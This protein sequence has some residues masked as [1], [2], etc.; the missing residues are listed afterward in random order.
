MNR[1]RKGLIIAASLCGAAVGLTVAISASVVGG[2][3][4]LVRDHNLVI[5]NEKETQLI[6]GVTETKVTTRDE[7]GNNQLVSY[8]TE[9][10]TSENSNI[11]V[12]AGYTDMNFGRVGLSTVRQQASIAQGLF[13]SNNENKTIIS[14]INA[15]PFNMSTG[16]NVGP[17][18]HDGVI[19][20]QHHGDPAQLGNA[21]FSVL[22]DG[23]FQT[24]RS[25]EEF[26]PQRETIAECVSGM[27]WL[28]HDGVTLDVDSNMAPDE[29]SWYGERAPRTAIGY[30]AA[31][32]LM[33]IV[34][35][36]RN[37]PIS[38]GA[39]YHEVAQMFLQRG[40][41]YAIALDG[42]GSATLLSKEEGDSQL[43]L[44]NVPSDGAE[45]RVGSSLLFYVENT[46]ESSGFQHA[47]I[48]PKNDYYTPT[49]TITFS[50]KGVDG[51]G[52]SADIPSGSSWA[53]ENP[54]LGTI[55]TI[56]ET[57]ARFTPNADTRGAVKVYLRDS[58][59]RNIGNTTI[60]I[61]LPDQLIFTNNEKS[62]GFD[63]DTDLGLQA[64]YQNVQVNYNAEDIDFVIK[65][66]SVS[67]NPSDLGY[68]NGTLFHSH[69]SNSI[70][71]TII[72]GLKANPSI[73]SSIKIIVGANPTVIDDFESYSTFEDLNQRWY[74]YNAEGLEEGDGYGRG[75]K[76]SINLARYDEGKP[77]RFG[78][79]SLE[80][81]WDFTAT[82]GGTSGSSAGF[83]DDNLEV[84]GAP[85]AYGAWI[86]ATPEAQG[87][88]LRARIVDGSGA[89]QQL[90]LTCQPSTCPPGVSHGINWIGWKYVE[91]P[92]NP[93]WPLPMY[94]AKGESLRFM[95]V[96]GTKPPM[97]QKNSG[98]FYVDNIQFVYG[99]NTD[100]VDSPII[101]SIQLNG[102]DFTEDGITV[103]TNS[104][105]YI[106]SFHDQEGTYAT[107]IDYD[108]MKINIDGVD[109]TD[110]S[111]LVSIN[112]GD[113]KL[114]INDL[115][116]ANGFHSIEIVVVD[117]FGNETS[118]MISFFVE[119]VENIEQAIVEAVPDD[120]A[121]LGGAFDTEL[122][123]TNGENLSTAQLI[124]KLGALYQDIDVT[125]YHNI[126]YTKSYN[127]NLRIMTINFDFTSS[128]LPKDRTLFA[129]VSNKLNISPSISATSV[130]TFE[131]ISG[132]F[133]QKEGSVEDASNTFSFPY[134]EKAFTSGLTLTV[135]P[136]LIGKDAVFTTTNGAGDPFGGVDVF[137][138]DGT[139]LG[140][141]DSKGKLVL[142]NFKNAIESINVYAKSPDGEFSFFVNTQ[143]FSGKGSGTPEGISMN[144]NT[145]NST[146]KNIS[147]FTN[148]LINDA[149][150]VVKYALKS[151]YE[152]DNSI[153]FKTAT[154][155]KA[156]LAFNSST[157]IAQN[158][159]ALSNN[160]TLTGL[161]PNSEYVYK[162]GNGDVFSELRSF[163]TSIPSGSA[164]FFVIG[165]A[166]SEDTSK[167]TDIIN[168]LGADGTNYDF[169]IQTGDFVDNVRSYE[170]WISAITSFQTSDV[171]ANTDILHVI[172]NHEIY[173]DSEARYTGSIYATTNP[174]HYSF[175]VGNVYIAMVGYSAS[176]SEVIES[177]N[178]LVEDAAKSK[179]TFKIL[180]MHQPPYY[181][182]PSGGNGFINKYGPAAIDAAG[183]DVVFSGH[184]HTLAKT[185]PMRG[186][187]INPF[188]TVYYICGST[189]EKS[190]SVVNNPEFN[191]EIATQ[192]YGSIYL[193]VSTND[194]SMTINI[195]DGVTSQLINS[196]TRKAVR[197]QHSHN[198]IYDNNLAT[199]ED[200]C[201]AFDPHVSGFTGLMETSSGNAVYFE[202]GV[203]STDDFIL[204]G[205][206][207]YGFDE[208]G[209]G[210]NGTFVVEGAQRI[211]VNGVLTDGY[212]GLVR[213]DK[214]LKLF[215][216]GIPQY[217]LI[218]Y[219]AEYYYFDPNN[220]GYAHIGTLNY[221]G[222]KY[223]F[224]DEPEFYGMMLA[225]FFFHSNIGIRYYYTYGTILGGIQEI[226]GAICYFD[227]RN[228][229]VGLDDPDGKVLY[230]I[231]TLYAKAAE[232]SYV[233]SVAD[234]VSDLK[235]NSLDTSF[236]PSINADI[237]GVKVPTT[238]VKAVDISSLFGGYDL[239]FKLSSVADMD[240]IS[241]NH[242]YL[243][244]DAKVEYSLVEETDLTKIWSSLVA[245][246]NNLTT[247]TLASY[248]DFVAIAE[249]LSLYK[250]LG[251][252]PTQEI[253]DLI[254]EKVAAYNALVKDA[255]DFADS[256]KIDSQSK[257]SSALVVAVSVVSLLAAAI[258]VAKKGRLI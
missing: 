172:G 10:K 229:L 62:V 127:A 142:S 3:G 173:G 143:S 235:S 138:L 44:R 63:V 23:S 162:V 140:T 250:K 129:T 188:G 25:Q 208:N 230:D 49:S 26:L 254:D 169:G 40:F 113:E 178:W 2:S 184:D 248:N 153:T 165:D 222:V 115:V 52:F 218:R 155:I 77:V 61:V 193:T 131:C 247:I 19:Y 198:Y 168:R 67:A 196:Y 82:D 102:R 46:G 78:Q 14:A 216:K 233:G 238:A 96:P 244:A 157:D 171:I 80:V 35:D 43:S 185:Q 81:N 100:D 225:E 71:G 166:Q 227:E 228:L 160:V 93:D 7:S 176:E 135:D 210:L 24:G 21:Y 69:A 205:D 47:N 51:S 191:F 180:T 137:L 145:G 255:N 186:G 211:Y 220:E 147:W 125:T 158:G 202:N 87:F 190:Y 126:T 106:A 85:T 32:D 146:I 118:K 66:D 76:N 134:I 37:A 88:W 139:K 130:Y 152:A 249:E 111:D 28:I 212:S 240:M 15:G 101:D 144:L 1:K 201:Y 123:A 257:I 141:T 17:L 189:G 174:K 253:L 219:Q 39:T 206:T 6:P 154:G 236:L 99:A 234:F 150:P 156:L 114:M 149:D 151:E 245:K 194:S 200:G 27:T 183:I 55:T 223:V 70:N 224:S 242:F 22:K 34:I 232:V 120:K 117:S 207:Y 42:G 108:R 213:D 84:E 182:N 103:D 68:M 161:M 92:I 97:G 122:F 33:T 58:S 258:F 251:G 197:N 119:G 195:Y 237:D 60:N 18:A 9:Y 36:G 38:V 192:D 83:R 256:V 243:I 45:R 159:V 163:D 109:Y 89:I 13:D 177:M 29:Y 64:Y 214:G 98:S 187:E 221:R 86:Y 167:L 16:R 57:Q 181:T 116:L 74:S 79:N 75:E 105:S 252:T 239:K 128:T 132:S 30:N 110:R 11:K 204:I 90:D 95:Y 8:I 231:Y 50:A 203:L 59:G 56:S 72:A 148:P 41:T 48:Y 199:C 170:Q 112:P 20:Q 53:L 94:F 217:G 73:S 104:I 91:A 226:D 5:T 215:E 65:P 175:E 124:V 121:V 164:N 4:G 179:A 12:S 31:G 107:G 246:I 209:Y 136:I 54:S 241:S 133:T